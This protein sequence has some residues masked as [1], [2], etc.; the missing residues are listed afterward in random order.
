MGPTA[1]QGYDFGQGAAL[2]YLIPI[3]IMLLAAVYLWLLRRTG[4][5]TS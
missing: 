3:A 4:T 1:Y 2:G 5:T